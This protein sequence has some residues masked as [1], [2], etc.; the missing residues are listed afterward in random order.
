[1]E[2]ALGL[3]VHGYGVDAMNTRPDLSATSC[4]ALLGN[5]NLSP[6]SDILVIRRTSTTLEDIA[7]LDPNDVYLQTT[8]ADKKM[9]IG[10]NSVNFTLTVQD[11]TSTVPADIRKFRTHVYFVAPCSAGTGTDGVCTAADDAIPTL[12]RLELS[13][14]TGATA[15]VINPLVEG[16]AYL[17]LDYGID[18][19]PDA[20]TSSSGL[21]GD[22]IPD[23]Y[24]NLP[25]SLTE[26]QNVMSVWVYLLSRATAGTPDHVDNKTYNLGT[27]FTVP[28]FRDAFR[29]KVFSSEIR[30]NN[31]AGRREAQ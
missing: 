28:P 18:A 11:G 19:T 22:S 21:T 13:G 14:E 12:K 1:M 7:L 5:T 24:V 20:A 23:T 3:P 6:G 10:L 9:D 25:S 4:G 29:R 16:V 31:Q 17:K 26:W 2:G 27:W 30:L 15:M 8:M